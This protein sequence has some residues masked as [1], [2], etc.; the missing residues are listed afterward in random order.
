MLATRPILSIRDAEKSYGKS[1]ALRGVTFDLYPSELL[2]FL[3][4]TVPGKPRSFVAWRAAV[5]W[6]GG[7]SASR[8]TPYLLGSVWYRSRSPC[9]K[10]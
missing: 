6:I 1:Q 8:S 3:G 2:G 10:T 5:D 9:I 7:T 4:R